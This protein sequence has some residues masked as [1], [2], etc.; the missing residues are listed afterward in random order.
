MTSST[1]EGQIKRRDQQKARDRVT[2]RIII[3]QLMSTD[4]GRRWVW[5][6]LEEGHIYDNNQDLDPM[7]MAFAK[8]ERNA[9]LRLLADVNKFCPT[10][11][12]IMQNES[13]KIIAYINSKDPNYVRSSDDFSDDSAD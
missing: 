11:Y 4:E 12:I 7:R 6:R 8:G 9:A 5:L 3:E 1:N 10:E 2:D 13:Q